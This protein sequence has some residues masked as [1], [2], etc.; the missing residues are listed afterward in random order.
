MLDIPWVPL[1]PCA[2]ADWPVGVCFDDAWCWW[3]DELEMLNLCKKFFCYYYGSKTIGARINICNKFVKQIL[4][5]I[6]QTMF[7]NGSSSILID[8]IWT[9]VVI[10]GAYDDE[11]TSSYKFLIGSWTKAPPVDRFL[12]KCAARRMTSSIGSAVDWCGSRRNLPTG[13]CANGSWTKGPQEAHN[14]NNTP[15]LACF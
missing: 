2:S 5:W 9:L 3:F 13:R 15:F 12:N 10:T 8:P 1:L 11:Q 6:I 14:N 4:W 7:T